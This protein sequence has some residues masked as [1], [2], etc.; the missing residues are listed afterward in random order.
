MLACRLGHLPSPWLC[1]GLQV[2]VSATPLLPSSK[3]LGIRETFK[4]S[5]ASAL[6]SHRG[7]GLSKGIGVFDILF[8]QMQN[9]GSSCL[10]PLLV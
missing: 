8:G 7:G 6:W 10:N 1:F 4:A 2:T 9:G 5:P 3:P